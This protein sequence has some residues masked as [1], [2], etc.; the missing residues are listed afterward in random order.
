MP[1]PSL[2]TRSR[3]RVYLKLP[4]GKSVIHYEKEKQGYLR[5]SRCSRILFGIPRLSSSE[6]RKL[7]MS[8]RRIKRMYGGQLCHTCLQDMLKEAVRSLS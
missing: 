7:S 4:G 2:R 6:L 5:C 3:K 8:Q 1:R